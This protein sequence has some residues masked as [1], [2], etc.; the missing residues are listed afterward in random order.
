MANCLASFQV[1]NLK[2]LPQVRS[3]DADSIVIDDIQIDGSGIAEVFDGTEALEA[4]FPHLLL[5]L[6]I[7]GEH[8]TFRR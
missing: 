8:T 7:E 5:L 2:I 4:G 6:Q 3:E 1:H